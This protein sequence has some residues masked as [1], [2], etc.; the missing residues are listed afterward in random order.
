MASDPSTSA[1]RRVV[2][3]AN[4]G[5]PPFDNNLLPAVRAFERLAETKVVAPVGHEGFV[6]T[7]GATPAEIPESAVEEA[8]GPGMPDLVICLGGGLV[9]KSR[10]RFA[11]RT[12]FVGVALSDPLGLAASFAIAPFFDLFYTQD[13][14]CLPAYRERGLDALRLDVAVDPELLAPAAEEAGPPRRDVIFYGKWTP[15]R[16][17]ILRRLDAELDVALFGHSWDESWSLEAR[18]ALG[19][20]ASLARE[21]ARSR[22]AL[23]L[24]RLDEAPE[25]W[26]GT[27]RITY[28]PFFAAACGMAS[29]VEASPRL[30]G[31]FRPG[32]EIATF[33]SPDDVVASARRLLAD[34][35]RRRE[36][37]E[38]ARRRV[39]EEHTWDHR[40]RQ[41]LR[42]LATVEARDAPS[43]PEAPH[44]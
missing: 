27:W 41:I 16:D 10:G 40:A 35:E 44:S 34:E 42:D 26:N 15:Y 13:P 17:E 20:S 18:P 21:I 28:R 11:T 33:G 19:D 14:Q 5:Q 8:L 43:S 39:R 29:L 1:P 12:R 23:E 30:E 9:P 3:F 32:E 37:G 36:M 6:G 2:I 24:A 22:V 4:L 25:P 7:G 38:A 31:Y